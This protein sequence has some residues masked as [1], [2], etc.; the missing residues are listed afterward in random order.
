MAVCKKWMDQNKDQLRDVYIK[1][2]KEF[3]LLVVTT[4]ISTDNVAQAILNKQ[5][6]EVSMGFGI[7]ASMAGQKVGLKPTGS[8]LTASAQDIWKTASAEVGGPAAGQVKL[9]S[10]LVIALL[11]RWR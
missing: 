4:V 10:C 11:V 6:Q 8:Y 5:T 1:E 9:I 3:G 7:T 2:M